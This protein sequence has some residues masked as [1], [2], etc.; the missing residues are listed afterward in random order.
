[1]DTDTHL[2]KCAH[3]LYCESVFQLLMTLAPMT[4][5][6]ASTVSKMTVY[7]V[8]VAVRVVELPHLFTLFTFLAVSCP[9][10]ELSIVYS[11]LACWTSR[12]GFGIPFTYPVYIRA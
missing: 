1:M 12:V 8:A 3:S 4:F 2:N 5:K 10:L 7:P 9:F 6:N 11:N